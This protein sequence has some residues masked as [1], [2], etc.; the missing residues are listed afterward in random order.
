[1]I[2]ELKKAILEDMLRLGKESG[3]HSF[4]QVTVTFSI[5]V[6]ALYVG[7]K[8]KTADGDPNLDSLSSTLWPAD[9]LCTS[10]PPKAY[11]KLTL[12][13]PAISLKDVVC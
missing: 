7:M 10:R 8:I 2:Q 13:Q 9:R 1:M 6:T 11:S 12:Q 5:L 4:E 3:L